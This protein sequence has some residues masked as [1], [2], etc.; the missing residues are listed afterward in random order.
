M[1]T[2]GTYKKEHFFSSPERLDELQNQLFTLAE[3]YEWDLQAWAIFG[4]H[5]HFIAQT[6]SDPATLRTFIRHLH[7]LTA[8]YVNRL[9]GLEGRK[10]WYQYWDSHLTF[11]RSYFARLKYVHLNPVKHGITEQPEEYPWCSARLFKQE[12]G[13]PYYRLVMNCKTDRVDVRDNF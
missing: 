6:K 1:I 3:K 10:V 4:N 11:E 13:S 12:A 2:A 5:Y 7:S 8:R 9:D